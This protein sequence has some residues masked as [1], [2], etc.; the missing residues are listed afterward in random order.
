MVPKVAGKGR[1]FTGAAQ[2]YLHDKGALTSARVAFSLTE[3]LPTRDARKAVK[4][5]AFTAMHQQEIKARAGGSAKGRR[6]EYPV[7]C[8]SLSWAPDETPSPEDMIGAAR[9]SMEALG[10]KGH[11]AVFVSHNDEPHPHIHVIVNRVHPETGIAAPLSNDHLKLSAWAEAY[12]KWQGKIRCEQRVEN[13]ARRRQKHFVKDQFSAKAADYYRWERLA[14]QEAF[15]RREKEQTE[16]TDAQKAQRKALY[17]VKERGIND[18]RRALHEDSRSR[19]R[20]TYLHQQQEREKLLLAQ[21]NTWSRLRHFLHTSAREY[22]STDRA[23]RSGFLSAGFAAIVGGPQQFAQLDKKHR[24]Y[25]ARVSE[26]V[27][28]QRREAFRDI[29]KDYRTGLDKLVAIQRQ[30]QQELQQRQLQEKQLSDRQRAEKEQAR[31]EQSRKRYGEI[32]EQKTDITQP[33]QDLR[34]RLRQKMSE[35][36]YQEIAEQAADITKPKARPAA[37]FEK[38]RGTSIEP[39]AARDRMRRRM[40]KKRYEEIAE[41]K[42]DITKPKAPSQDQKAQRTRGKYSAFRELTE[43]ITKPRWK[44]G[45]DINRKPPKGPE[46]R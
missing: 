9:E 34:T 1:S 6:L 25:R 39:S 14:L 33:S 17:D 3:N 35:R 26:A 10:L 20:M 7:Y 44:G 30:Q 24:T 29:N 15:V 8:Y 38:V 23:S 11:E 42:E 46:F 21:R 19:W 18:K 12:E 40:S 37:D 4:C 13:N 32:A 28:R 27:D 45:R 22:F 41:T 43:E 16:L 31:Q 5:M 2:Y 36:R